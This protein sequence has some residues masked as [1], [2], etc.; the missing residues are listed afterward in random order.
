MLIIANISI[1]LLRPERH[2]LHIRSAYTQCVPS[3][4]GSTTVPLECHRH[5]GVNSWYRRGSPL[6]VRHAIC[7]WTPHIHTQGRPGTIFRGGYRRGF[8]SQRLHALPLHGEARALEHQL[9]DLQR[10]V[11][12]KHGKRG[13]WGTCT[14]N[15]TVVYSLPGRA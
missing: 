14:G 13:W 11:A 15:G 2:A 1:A 8:I 6:P 9:L 12:Q 10:D 5:S 7:T 4:G 3:Q